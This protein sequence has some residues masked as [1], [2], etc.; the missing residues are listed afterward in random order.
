MRVRVGPNIIKNDRLIE[1]AMLPVVGSRYVV[2]KLADVVRRND[3]RGVRMLAAAPI[4]L[5]N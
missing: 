1:Q 2:M 4:I 5:R 3:F